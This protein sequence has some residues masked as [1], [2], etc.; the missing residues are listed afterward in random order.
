MISMQLIFNDEEWLPCLLMLFVHLG[1]EVGEC[2]SHM[3][4]GLV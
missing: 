4:P 1:M 2:A 3:A